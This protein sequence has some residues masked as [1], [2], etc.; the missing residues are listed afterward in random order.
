MT[1]S[2]DSPH[3][4]YRPYRLFGS[5]EIRRKLGG[6]TSVTGIMLGHRKPQ[7]GDTRSSYSSLQL[8]LAI[9]AIA[10][11]QVQVQV[12]VCR[13]LLWCLFQG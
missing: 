6:I 1:C 5:V 11:V 13:A 9:A 8:G 3:G 2:S 4:P 7:F 12:G 10:Q